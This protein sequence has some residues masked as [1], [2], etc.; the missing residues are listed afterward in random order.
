MS[1]RQGTDAVPIPPCKGCGLPYRPEHHV[2]RRW[3]SPRRTY[4]CTCG[5]GPVKVPVWVLVELGVI[6]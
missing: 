4:Q 5:A 2:R 3:P 1:D 6:G